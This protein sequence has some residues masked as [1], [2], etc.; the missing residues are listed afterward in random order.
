MWSLRKDMQEI[1]SKSFVR[2]DTFN[3]VS[4]ATVFILYVYCLG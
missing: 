4:S 1:M 2:D 3:M